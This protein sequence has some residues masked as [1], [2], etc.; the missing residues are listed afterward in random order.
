MSSILDTIKTQLGIEKEVDHFDE[1]LILHI[2]T[3]LLSLTQL[4]IGPGNGFMITGRVDEW[5]QFLGNRLDLEAAKTLVYLKVRVSF[6]P[7]TNSFL[8]ESMNK[9]IDELSWR[10]MLQLGN[11]MEV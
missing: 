2:N 9:T 1:E 10:L 4:G 7:P 8:L 11:V 3:A 6:D 5:S